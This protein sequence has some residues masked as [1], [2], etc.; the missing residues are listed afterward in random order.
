MAEESYE[1]IWIYHEKQEALLCGQHALNNLVQRPAFTPYQL[2][3]LAHQLDA[4]ELEYMAQNNEGGTRSVEYQQRLQEGSSNVDEAGNFSI[5]VLKAALLEQYQITLDHLN[6]RVLQG[7]DITEMQGFICHKSDH[8]FALRNIGGRFW[9]LNSTL[10]RPE[11]VSHFALATEMKETKKL[12]YT[13]FAI[14]TGLPPAGEKYGS[15]GNNWHRMSDLLKGKSTQADPWEKLQGRGMRLDGNAANAGA[16]GGAA[17]AIDG[18]T[19]DEQIALALQQSLEPPP[20]VRNVT[21]EF[22]VPEE[23]PKGEKGSCRIQL[24]LPDGSRLVRPFRTT[25]LVGG[26]FAV[27]ASKCGGRPF[28]LLAGFPPKDIAESKHK[29]I[30]EAGLAGESIQG[31]FI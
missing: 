2:S 13:I 31:R 11:P 29:S 1:S 19:E 10:E 17:M 9:N 8:W 6:D 20:V 7:R 4:L 5:Q 12:G 22:A 15:A 16:S 14:P 28:N 24:R 30:G 23:P 21:E 26:I 25:D 18:L 27:V 3:Q